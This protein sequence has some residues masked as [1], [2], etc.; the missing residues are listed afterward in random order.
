MSKEINLLNN[1][2]LFPSWVLANFKKYKLEP[3]YRDAS[4]DPC[5]QTKMKKE[6]HLYQKFLSAYL[7]YNSPFK[8]LLIYH[9]YGSGKTVSAIN[10]Y[11]VLFNHTPKWNLFILIKAALKNDPWMKD[12]NDWLGKDDKEKRMNNIQF[13]HYDSPFADRDFLEVVKT[14]R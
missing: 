12:L 11:N 3:L 5:Q 13:I 10:I 14:S 1:G 8:D 4:K 9:G 6:L 7:S 2:R